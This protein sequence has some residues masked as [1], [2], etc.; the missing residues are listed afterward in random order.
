MGNQSL[1][2]FVLSSHFIL[3]EHFYKMN[4]KIVS[5]LCTDFLLLILFLIPFI[6]FFI[7][8]MINVKYFNLIN[9]MSTVCC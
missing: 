9:F 3:V 5:H 4:F 8:L 7:T 2:P 6:D 1:S